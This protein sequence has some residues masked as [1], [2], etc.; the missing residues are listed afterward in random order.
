M[1]TAKP[2]LAAL[3]LSLC[4]SAANAADSPSSFS[5]KASDARELVGKTVQTDSG[6]VLGK[7]ND[8]TVDET[9]GKS[10]A[11][12][13]YGKQRFTAVPLDH[14]RSM[15][16]K[17]SIVLDRAQLEGAPALKDQEW[18][19]QKSKAWGTSADQYWQR[20]SPTRSASPNATPPR[21]DV[22]R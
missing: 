22:Q 20:G 2:L 3:A 5:K 9:Q 1:K 7:V 10:Y 18:R 12:I 13:S 21:A 14:V 19:D 15:V 6:E 17:D 11:I 16:K 8:V 4:F